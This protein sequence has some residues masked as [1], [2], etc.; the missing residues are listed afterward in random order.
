VVLIRQKNLARLLKQWQQDPNQAINLLTQLNDLSLVKDFV[1][2][3]VIGWFG[4]NLL[5]TPALLAHCRKL[6]LQKYPQY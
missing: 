2:S 4:V 6:T 5:N 3:A 1:E